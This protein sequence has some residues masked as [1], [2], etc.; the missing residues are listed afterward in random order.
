LRDLQAFAERGGFEIVGIFQEKM[1]GTKIDR[2]Q[3]KQVINLAQARKIDAVLV[4]ELT[5]WGRSTIDLLETLQQLNSWNVS[6][7]V[8]WPR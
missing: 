6:V 5:R 1:S 2:E 7:I 3:R 8:S 4:T